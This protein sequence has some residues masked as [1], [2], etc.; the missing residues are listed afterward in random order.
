MFEFFTQFNIYE[1]EK[2]FF[3][4]CSFHWC[5]KLNVHNIIIIIILE[6]RLC[7]IKVKLIMMSLYT[8]RQKVAFSSVNN[9]LFVYFLDDKLF[10]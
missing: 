2:L 5:A 3:K 6:I 1:K 7:L 9:K 10:F 4:N 8:M